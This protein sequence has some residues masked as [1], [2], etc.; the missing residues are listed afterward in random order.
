[1]N[2]QRLILTLVIVTS[3]IVLGLLA[4]TQVTTRPDLVVRLTLAALAVS[5]FVVV[6]VK[7]QGLDST[8]YLFLI[9][10]YLAA[11]FAFNPSKSLGYLGP[12]VVIGGS[13]VFYALSKNAAILNRFLLIVAL[14]GVMTFF[15]MVVNPHFE[16][17]NS[18]IAFFTYS[19]FYPL[20]MFS[21]RRLV[22]E[23]MEKRFLRAVTWL[24][25][26]QCVIGVGQ[27]LFGFYHSRISR[28]SPGDYVEGTLHILPFASGSLSN[29]MFTFNLLMCSVFL[30]YTILKY[31]KRRKLLLALAILTMCMAAVVHLMI[32]AI[33]AIAGAYILV[34]PKL[35][36]RNSMRNA[37]S[38]TMVFGSLLAIG[39]LL[40]TGAGHFSNRL[41]NLIEGRNF[42]HKT[43]SLLWDAL[44]ED[45]PQILVMGA[46]PGQFGSRAAL[47]AAGYLGS[48]PKG[49]SFVL[50][51]LF[52]TYLLADWI[53]WFEIW[54]HSV[55][56]SP[57]SSWFAVISEWGF[58]T[59]GLI[60]VF[61]VRSAIRSMIQM[62]RY[63]DRQM[64]GFFYLICLFILLVAGFPTFYW[65]IPQA[66]FLACLL[67]KYFHAKLYAAPEL[68]QTA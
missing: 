17:Q 1:M 24:V 32:V 62:A 4:G 45:E 50:T 25:F 64:E 18:A 54:W 38:G 40:G 63:P 67:T 33:V 37:L 43:Y 36:G 30:W 19:S 48:L 28:A 9:A 14:W 29:A 16:L 35:F 27:G 5:L 46:G 22:N 58:I 52:R 31:R 34:R 26:I 7:R 3:V 68:E 42:K 47:I 55:A 11:V 60:L 6:G 10:L 2:D 61:S 65:E 21:H 57:A 41:E 39:I 66:I 56:N 49:F 15:Y 12:M 59:F 44:P 53:S 51:D 13:I 8:Q 20:L 23:E